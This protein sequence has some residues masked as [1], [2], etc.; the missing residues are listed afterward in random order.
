MEVGG[1]LGE[2]K[3]KMHDGDVGG[4]SVVDGWWL[5]EVVM[6]RGRRPRGGVG[7]AG[8]VVARQQGERDGRRVAELDVGMERLEVAGMVVL[9]RR[10]MMARLQPGEGAFEVDTGWLSVVL[11]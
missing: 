7:L 8:L 2:I 3:E 4:R 10:V 11:S 6:I 9:V 1:C 5:T